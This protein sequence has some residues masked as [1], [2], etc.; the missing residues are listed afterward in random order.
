MLAG[1][2][3]V[4]YA[5]LA[6][7]AHIYP[8]SLARIYFMP[9]NESSP[10]SGYISR[11]NIL[12]HEMHRTL[13]MMNGGARGAT[14]EAHDR[15]EYKEKLKRYIVEMRSRGC[16][17]SSIANKLNAMG[18]FGANGGRW[19]QSSVRRYAPYADASLAN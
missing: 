4:A 15:L 10:E 13:Q 6:R 14:N 16:T 19:Y 18:I 11:N 17:Y 1:S 9:I 2:R 5:L 3:R 8:F 12:Y 7:Y